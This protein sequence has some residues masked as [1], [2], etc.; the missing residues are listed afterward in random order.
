MG[1]RGFQWTC[2]PSLP[3]SCPQL[4]QLSK[5][6]GTA[7]VL[8]LLRAGGGQ[9]PLGLSVSRPLTVPASGGFDEGLGISLRG[10]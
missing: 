6:D 5:Q 10:F 4:R 2:S 1:G 8:R 3:P 9:C 7:G